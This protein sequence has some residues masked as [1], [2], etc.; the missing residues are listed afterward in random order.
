ME[1]IVDA[2]WHEALFVHCLLLVIYSASAVAD[3][4]QER[5]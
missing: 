1:K 3:A 2:S 4:S 5:S